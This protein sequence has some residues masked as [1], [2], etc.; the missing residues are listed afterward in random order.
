MS[1]ESNK[2]T[3][4]FK[5]AFKSIKDL[6]KYEDFALE[7]P[8]KAFKY[9]IK[10][11]VIFCALICVC[12]TYQIVQN[13]ND[14]YANFKNE[15]PNFSYADGILK[16]DSTEPILL[17]EYKEIL[18]KIVIDTNIL[19]N[20][21][22]KYGKDIKDGNVGVLVLKDKCII[23]SNGAMG[24]V[25]YK[26]EDIAKNYGITEFTKQ[27]VINYVE[28]INIITIYSSI[29]F[30]IFVYLFLAY[31]ISILMDVLLLSILA[32]FVSRISKINMKFAPSFTIAV[33]AITLPAILN[34]VYIIVNLFTGFTIKYFGLM[35]SII[36]YIYVIVA[37]L[38]IKTDFINR[39]IEL[40]KIAAEQEKIKEEMKRKE[41]EEKKKQQEENKQPEK[42][43]KDKKEE[44]T[45]KRK[46][47]NEEEKGVGADAPACQETGK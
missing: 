45:N 7:Q 36:S 43:N 12:Y 19:E 32:Y 25:T 41:E 27:D 11:I 10:L 3:N 26:Y 44:N 40:M 1:E 31:G 17:E 16:L 4:F 28:G 9:L 2:K 21:V 23:L 15:L 14:I 30:V 37:I 33:H 46:K 5:E 38:M 20:E 39:Q 29:Y 24:Q 18:G 13:M 35:Y 47:K 42:E 34:L 22:E 8:S 6:D